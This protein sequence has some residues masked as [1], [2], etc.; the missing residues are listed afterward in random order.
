MNGREIADLLYGG[1]MPDRRQTEQEFGA[2]ILAR[3]E[4]HFHIAREVWGEHCSGQR[5][6]IDAIVRP[7]QRE[8]WKNPDIALG[9]EFKALDQLT[10]W[11]A[12]CQW[13]GQCGDYAHANWDG[14][15]KVWVFA[16]PGLVAHKH[17]A[18]ERQN[19][20]Y[21]RPRGPEDASAETQRYYHLLNQF[22]LGE[23]GEDPKYGLSFYVNFLHRLWSEGQGVELGKT[24][25]LDHSVGRR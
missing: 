19:E 25:S 22:Q 4:P 18:W 5:L 12:C 7:R 17:H 20:R 24:H 3:L 9:I 23:L 15:G 16:S 13:I 11:K 2:E 1:K 6:R 10:T 21:P 8:L 14:F